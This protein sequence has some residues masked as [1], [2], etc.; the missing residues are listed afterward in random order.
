MNNNNPLLLEANNILNDEDYVALINNVSSSIYEYALATKANFQEIQ[1]IFELMDDELKENKEIINFLNIS[2][3]NENNLN[4]FFSDAKISF[5]NLKL[6]RKEY[7]S[8]VYNYINLIL[9]EKKEKER[10]MGKRQY[11]QG[12]LNHRNHNEG[13]DNMSR[14]GSSTINLLS[15]LKKY[16]DIIGLYSDEDKEQY[17]NLIN[18]LFRE[19]KKYEYRDNQEENLEQI[20]EEIQNYKIIINKYKESDVK[21]RQ[22]LSS[23][24]KQLNNLAQNNENNLLPQLEKT[25]KFNNQLKEEVKRERLN[26]MKKDKKIKELKEQNN[27]LNKKNKENENII[28]NNENKLISLSEETQI[29][30]LKINELNRINTEKKDIINNLKK[31]NTLITN[32]NNINTN[33]NNNN[34]M[35]EDLSKENKLLKEEIENKEKKYENLEK[36]YNELKETNNSME[37]NQNIINNKNNENIIKLKEEINNNKNKI[38]LLENQLKNKEKE[39]KLK[40]IDYDKLKNELSIKTNEFEQLKNVIDEEKNKYDKNISE[41]NKNTSKVVDK[42]NNEI[43]EL[44]NDI[45]KYKLQINE[46]DKII[47]DYKDKINSNKNKNNNDEII[48]EN[49]KNEKKNLQ[50]NIDKTNN[51]LN[52]VKKELSQKDDEYYLLSNENNHLKALIKEYKSQLKEEKENNSKIEELKSKNSQ[53]IE[54]LNLQASQIGN[55]LQTI[56]E[57]DE[58]I[59]K[60]K[61]NYLEDDRIT[62]FEN[63]IKQLQEKNRLLLE[64]NK[65]LKQSKVT[66]IQSTS[67]QMVKNNQ[68]LNEYMEKVRELE[69]EKLLLESQLEESKKQSMRVNNSVN[70][71]YEEENIRYKNEIE[72]LKK[73][74]KNL[75]KENQ[76]L[77]VVNEELKK[78]IDNLKKKEDGKCLT[79]SNN[80]SNFEEEYDVYDLANNA[81]EKNNS[82]DMKIDFPGLNDINTK[83][84]ELK[85]NIDESKELIKEIISSSQCEDPDIQ[86]KVQRVCEILEISFD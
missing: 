81:K 47:K 43:D 72:N 60:L 16:I 74:I 17:I 20:N 44:K 10:T 86:Q 28:I 39:Y 57:K 48:I 23:L 24:Q 52:N 38:T 26:S 33:N 55:Y 14:K 40:V 3:S 15:N 62:Q 54:K 4:T 51:E 49:L 85:K 80:L 12:N 42:L 76:L 5:K 71:L 35:L 2:K 32:N 79:M 59:K 46:Q 21:L 69:Q 84:I 11:S 61:S 78:K 29:Y 56:N 68:S 31:E 25:L 82:E 58:L 83:Y 1:N 50:I 30:K 13:G 41:S 6:V 53:N 64:E 8:N 75:E 70:F 7:L 36:K 77:K 66:L 37:K 19:F 34:N 65:D 67:Q 63:D 27:N 73:K 18:L 9:S 45:N 22:K